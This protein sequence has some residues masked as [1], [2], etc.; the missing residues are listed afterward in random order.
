MKS[1]SRRTHSK[2]IRLKLGTNSTKE[3][4]ALDETVVVNTTVNMMVQVNVQNLLLNS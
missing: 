1:Q 2:I 4:K 3:S